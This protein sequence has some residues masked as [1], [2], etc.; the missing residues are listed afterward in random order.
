MYVSHVLMLIYSFFLFF[1]FHTKQDQRHP[2][3]Q[4]ASQHIFYIKRVSVII[5]C[6]QRS[7]FLPCCY[8]K[9]STKDRKFNEFCHYFQNEKKNKEKG[10]EGKGK[11]VQTQ[12]KKLTFKQQI[13]IIVPVMAAR[14]S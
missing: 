11:M 5:L 12:Y 4:V 6:P 3:Q 13:I 7:H 10:K 14:C 1:F 8:F 2:Y 9:Y